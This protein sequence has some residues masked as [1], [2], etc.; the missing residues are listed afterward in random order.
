MAH[1]VTVVE[2]RELQA[3]G[4]GVGWGRVG[5]GRGVDRERRTRGVGGWGLDGLWENWTLVTAEAA[6]N[7]HQLGIALSTIF[8]SSVPNRRLR[9]GVH[10]ASQSKFRLSQCRGT[11]FEWACVTRPRLLSAGPSCRHC[12][13]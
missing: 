12:R 13:C 4:D 9:L 3:A 1:S 2:D 6:A 5:A 11:W 10:H 8:F 7:Y